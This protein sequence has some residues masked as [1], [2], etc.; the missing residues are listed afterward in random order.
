MARRKEFAQGARTAI[1]HRAVGVARRTLP[2]ASPTATGVSS[3]AIR[4][5]L[6]V[7]LPTST[8]LHSG[9][10]PENHEFVCA[11]PSRLALH[12]QR[13]AQRAQRPRPLGP[14]VDRRT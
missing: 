13:H 8:P 9:E 1:G 10:F 11:D 14:A 4:N 6:P 12:A 7:F 5:P 3:T 2:T